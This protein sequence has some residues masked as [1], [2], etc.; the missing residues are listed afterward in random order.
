MKLK[1]IWV[2]GCLAACALALTGC[3]KPGLAGTSWQASRVELDTGGTVN[4]EDAFIISGEMSLAGKMASES[5]ER[6]S[7]YYK[8]RIDARIA[9]AGLAEKAKGQKDM[10]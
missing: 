1:A 3:A 9:N 4:G 5:I 7:M 6:M 10:D 8:G 2:L